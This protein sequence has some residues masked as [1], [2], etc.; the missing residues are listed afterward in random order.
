MALDEAVKQARLEFALE[1]AKKA[2]Y[3]ILSYFQQQ[4]LH[5]DL[6]H[7]FSPVAT[8]ICP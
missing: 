8:R 6:K 5:V 3:L 1:I 7:D 2:G 4:D